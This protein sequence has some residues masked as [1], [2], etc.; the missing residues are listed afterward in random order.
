MDVTIYGIRYIYL[1]VCDIRYMDVV[2]CDI[3]HMNVVIYNIWYMYVVVYD[4]QYIDVVMVCF[5]MHEHTVIFGYTVSGVR[6]LHVLHLICIL[7]EQ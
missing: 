4:I 3:W 6:C 1:A 2:F 7:E 5:I